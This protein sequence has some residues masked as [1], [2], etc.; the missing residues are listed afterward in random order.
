MVCRRLEIESLSYV[1][2]KKYSWIHIFQVNEEIS[3][4][5]RN[6]YRA[7]YFQYQSSTGTLQPALFQ[8]GHLTPKADFDQHAQRASFS[9]SNNIHVSLI[10]TKDLS[11]YFVKK[12]TALL[13]FYRFSILCSP[14]KWIQHVLEKTWE[15]DK[16]ERETNPRNLVFPVCHF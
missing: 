13:S 2:R 6:Y 14:I 10:K 4:T 1:Q 8:K 9:F 7:E 12:S 15:K 5:A 11:S 16:R 3:F